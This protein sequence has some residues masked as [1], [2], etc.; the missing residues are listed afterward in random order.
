M[1]CP[2]CKQDKIKDEFKPFK[3]DKNLLQTT[4]DMVCGGCGIKFSAEVMRTISMG[5]RG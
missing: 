4:G 2:V 1:K 3:G 5:I